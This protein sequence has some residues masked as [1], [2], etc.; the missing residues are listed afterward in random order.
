MTA[1]A[2]DVSALLIE[3]ARGGLAKG[4]KKIRHCVDQLN[5][6]Q[7]WWRPRPEMNSIANL[8][9]H[10]A[11]NLRQWIVSGVGG[12]PDVRDRPVEFA[13]RSG[14]PKSEVVAKLESVVR[15]C[16]AVFARL[17]PD[18]LAAPRRI[19]G[20]DATVTSAILDVISHLQGHVQEIIHM[21]REQL[22]D[23]YRFDFVPKGA[24]QTSAGGRVK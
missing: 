18:D 17:G 22:G 16:D 10:L 14:A 24:E 21:T 8:L 2:N 4:L 6:E 1:T 11:G 15:D 19:Q 3:G 12:A 7:L 5:D 9:L 23:G 20:F 13:D